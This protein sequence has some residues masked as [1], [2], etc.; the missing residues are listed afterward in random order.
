MGWK[1]KGYLNTAVSRISYSKDVQWI[2]VST[3][4]LQGRRCC[5]AMGV[6]IVGIVSPS[7]SPSLSLSLLSLHPPTTLSYQLA[8]DRATSNVDASNPPIRSYSFT[9]PTL[10]S[11]FRSSSQSSHSSSELYPRSSCERVLNA[12]ILIWSSKKL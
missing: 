9:W 3:V 2:Y 12:I 5:W 8:R 4:S 11:P 10:Y 1:C 7:Q 6:P